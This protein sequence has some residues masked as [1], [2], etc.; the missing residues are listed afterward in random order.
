MVKHILVLLSVLFSLSA[1]GAYS[2]GTYLTNETGNYID[3]RTRTWNLGVSD[4]IN[5]LNFPSSFNISNFPTSFQ[6]SN[7]PSTQAVTGSVSVTNFGLGLTD[8]QLR[9]SPLSVTGTFWQ[10]L[11]PVSVSSLPLPSGAAT[12]ANQATANALLDGI[13]T[14]LGGTLT[15][16]GGGGGSSGGLTNTEL[17]ASPVSVSIS[18]GAPGGSTAANQ[19]TANNSLAS[20]DTKLTSPLAVT[21]STL[22]LPAGAATETTLAAMSAKIPVIGQNTSANSQPVVLA[23][24]QSA[25]AAKDHGLLVSGTGAALNADPVPV[26][27]VSG[28]STAMLHLTG[29]W[30]GTFTPQCSNDNVNFVNILMQPVNTQTAMVGS[31]TSGGLFLAPL[32]CKFFRG[33]LTAFTSG[34][35]TANVEFSSLAPPFMNQQSVTVAGGVALTA[36]SATIGVL[37]TGSAMSNDVGIQYRATSTGAALAVHTV[38]AATT[39]AVLVKASAGR[40]LGFQA[41]NS[42]TTVWRYVKFYNLATT[43][44]PGTSTVVRTVGLPPNQYVDFNMEGGIAHTA[45]IGIAITSGAADN[46]ATAVSAANEVVVD[47]LYQ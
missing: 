15:V 5:V 34:T 38:A 18:S 23:T 44:V 12:A 45:G 9:A 7:F 25:I 3:P 24:D 16:T 19:V 10:A 4:S 21:A 17:R 27:D 11:Q 22:P 30:A 1:W 47:V 31:T 37:G 28:F 32:A 42:S 46:D 43:P 14:K 39:N 36:S 33:R 20:I 41:F 13:N 2:P 40:V 26:T 29:T 35:L 8:T 6:V